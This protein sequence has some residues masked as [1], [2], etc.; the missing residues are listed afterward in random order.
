MRRLLYLGLGGFSSVTVKWLLSCHRSGWLIWAKG[1]SSH[2]W[3]VSR[4]DLQYSRCFDG[5]MY[6]P[7][8]DEQA[9]N[10]LRRVYILR[11]FS[12]L[13]DLS[14][15]IFITY[16]Q[17]GSL[18]FFLHS[19]P[20][21]WTVHSLHSFLHFTVHIHSFGYPG[22]AFLRTLKF[23]SSYFQTLQDVLS[24]YPPLGPCGHN[25]GSVG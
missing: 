9:I 15:H 21:L 17:T 3:G 16:L 2:V 14:S 7:C 18:D 6:D 23:K 1:S 13:L 24:S 8:S 19:F 4:Y 25:S 10:A 5:G 20:V 11:L 12:P 22:G